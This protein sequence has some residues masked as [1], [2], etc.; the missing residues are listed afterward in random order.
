M[1]VCVC[2]CVR[3]YKFVGYRFRAVIHICVGML[4]VHV[5][6]PKGG[7]DCMRVCRIVQWLH[8]K[9]DT[10]VPTLAVG[11]RMGPHNIQI[12]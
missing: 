12:L 9:I 4:H 8:R 10:E 6:V 2:A 1:M 5:C 11:R 7:Y 3:A